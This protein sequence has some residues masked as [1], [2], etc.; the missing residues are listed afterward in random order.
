[1]ST[2]N[3]KLDS[4]GKFLLFNKPIALVTGMTDEQIYKMNFLEAPWWVDE[5]SKQRIKDAFAQA[6]ASGKASLLDERVK[7]L[8][9]RI[10]YLNISIVP[11]MDEKGVIQ[12]LVAEGRD[13]TSMKAA[14]EALKNRTIESERLD[15]L[16][17][18][19]E[20]KMAELK[21]EIERLSRDKKSP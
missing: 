1:M 14:E 2:F 19:R 18:G 6:I 12:Y 16:M 7:V 4:S 13:I 21:K 20:L 17:V 11:I 5:A 10:L 9:G 15:A 3:A 8:N